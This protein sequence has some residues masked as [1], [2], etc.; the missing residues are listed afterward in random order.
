MKRK[1]RNVFLSVLT[2]AV[3]SLSAVAGTIYASASESEPILPSDALELNYTEG[4][5]ESFE[6]SSLEKHGF[7]SQTG[8]GPARIEQDANGNYYMLLSYNGSNQWTSAYFQ[9]DA[10]ISENGVYKFTANVKY[11]TAFTGKFTLQ[12]FNSDT[13]KSADI[14]IATGAAALDKLVTGTSGE[15]KTISTF[16]TVSGYETALYNKIKL[17]L[18]TYNTE[19]E[20]IIDDIAICKQETVQEF[21]STNIDADYNGDLSG[22]DS[23]V[24]ET[25]NTIYRFAA[26]ENGVVNNFTNHVDDN[27]VIVDEGSNVAKLKSIVANGTAGIRWYVGDL[28]S[29]NYRLSIDAKKGSTFTGSAFTA[30]LRSTGENNQNATYELATATTTGYTT[31]TASFNVTKERTNA[32]FVIFHQNGG[33]LD[34]NCY[35]LID[36]LKLEKETVESGVYETAFN[37]NGD[38]E[39]FTKTAE[40][41][42]WGSSAIV[43]NWFVAAGELQ[44]VSVVDDN[45]NSVVKL[46]NKTSASGT[47][48]AAA[49][50]KILTKDIWQGGNYKISFKLKGGSA[51]T[52]N[53]IGFRIRNI[54]NV[55]Y[56]AD[57]TLSAV[58]LSSIG[59]DSWTTVE[60]VFSINGASAETVEPR[61][62]I[63]YFNNSKPDENNYLLIDDITITKETV[64]ASYSENKITQVDG[65]FSSFEDCLGETFTVNESAKNFGLYPSDN[66]AERVE[67][68]FKSSET[69]ETETFK[70]VKFSNPEEN[71]KNCSFYITNLNLPDPMEGSYKI[72]FEIAFSDDAYSS[73]IGTRFAGTGV[74][75][76]IL[77]VG[78]SSDIA[79]YEEDADEWGFF[80]VSGNIMIVRGQV[81]DKIQLWVS[82]QKGEAYVKNL[83]I[84]RDTENDKLYVD[85]ITPDS[86][87]QFSNLYKGGD[88][89]TNTAGEAYRDGY[90]LEAS[91]A[92]AQNGFGTITLDSTA[93]V[94]R[95]GENSVVKLKYDGHKSTVYSSLFLNLS[96]A[97]INLADIFSLQ[98]DYKMNES[99]AGANASL[100]GTGNSSL[101][102]VN[103]VEAAKLYEESTLTDENGAKYAI[104][105]ATGAAKMVYQYKVTASAVLDGYLHIDFF[106]RMDTNV[107]YNLQSLR[108]LLNNKQDASESGPE[109]YL[110]NIVYGIWESEEDYTQRVENST[111]V[112]PSKNSTESENGCFSTVSGM[113]LAS[114]VTFVSAWLLRKKRKNGMR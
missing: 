24:E 27:T 92:T 58:Q 62:D 64:A 17:L 53:N 14:T 75:T 103:L 41:Y 20:L 96:A 83:V 95:E 82:I 63:W 31:L 9:D 90:Y 73:N 7:V 97:D 5:V 114:T 105:Y 56:V 43:N 87:L 21:S 1:T 3:L 11:S 23:A 111:V 15:Y 60:F 93:Q 30:S 91:G 112:Y 81:I 77:K 35:L 113:G 44:N 109:M 67:M 72:S 33:P 28:A 4:F 107:L 110:D 101:Y 8:D 89:E 39:D 26:A 61:L 16:F 65:T 47:N 18:T 46:Q 68:Q 104:G 45:G 2:M 85:Y 69:G 57:T 22:F 6:L 10:A 66:P 80:S 88:F 25:K 34:D 79:R 50:V 59:S 32:Y 74:T 94:V 51:F 86:G 71:A 108:F 40:G 78:T 106:F 70:V 19:N 29:G 84:E 55:K 42:F 99:V 100:L 38:F 49:V 36:N 52:S 98:F 37:T 12:L 76:E 54:S 13:H 102:M 48:G